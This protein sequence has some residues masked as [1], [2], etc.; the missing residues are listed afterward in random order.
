MIA[1]KGYPVETHI[2]ETKDCY[3]LTLHRIPH[4]RNESF[5]N[6]L[7]PIVFLQHGLL[8]SSADW[9][10]GNADDSLGIITL[11]KNSAFKPV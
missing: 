4:G 8:C 3:K 10:M 1:V 7:R 9:I 11:M 5:S 2:V 6:G